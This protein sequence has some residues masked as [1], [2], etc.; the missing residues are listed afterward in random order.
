VDK[1]KETHGEAKKIVPLMFFGFLVFC[2]VVLCF[3]YFF[4]VFFLNAFKGEDK[5][6]RRKAIGAL[7]DATATDFRRTCA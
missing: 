4:F 6:R 3:Y 2:V 1:G 5:M 7:Q